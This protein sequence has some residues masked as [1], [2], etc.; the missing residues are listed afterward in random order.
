[1]SNDLLIAAAC[2]HRA[3][4]VNCVDFLD[5]TKNIYAENQRNMTL[6][7]YTDLWQLL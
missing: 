7:L 6:K 3:S 1:M 5:T 4:K 2:L